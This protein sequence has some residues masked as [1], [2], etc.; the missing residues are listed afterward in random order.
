MTDGEKSE[1]PA[2]ETKPN[3]SKDKL[4]L[5]HWTQSFISQKVRLVINEKGLLCEE[6]DVSLPIAEHNEPWFMRL[7]LGEEVPVFIHGDT[8]VSDYNQIIQY[9]EANFGGETVAQLIPD[10]GSPVHECVQQYRELLDG[11]PMDAYTHGCIL[12]PELTTDSMIPKYA[13]AEIRRHLANAASEL[14]KLDHEEPTLTEPYLS[15]QK[16]LMAKILDHDNVTYLKKILGELAMVLDQ[17]EAELEKRKIEYEG[18][19]LHNDCIEKAKL[20]IKLFSGPWEGTSLWEK[21]KKREKKKREEKKKRKK[22]K[23][24]GLVSASDIL[25]ELAQLNFPDTDV[26]R[27]CL[28]SLVFKCG[29]ARLLFSYLTALLC[30]TGLESLMKKPTRTP[31]CRSPTQRQEKR[32]EMRPVCAQLLFAAI[33]CS[34][35]YTGAAA[36]RS[37]SKSNQT[38]H[39]HLTRPGF[40]SD[41]DSD[42]SNL[43][44]TSISVPRIRRRRAIS[45]REINSLLDYHNLVRSQVFPQAANMEIM[46]RPASAEPGQE[47]KG[48]LLCHILW[49]GLLTL[50]QI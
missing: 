32:V 3:F 26:K 22:K 50:N 4:V 14:L 29:S 2:I 17:V 18:P 36:V 16:K 47:N 41:P 1:E 46:V 6:R 39:L 21:K 27:S 49:L 42:W 40:E 20:P 23:T 7:N 44:L 48:L 37:L 35:P 43:N 34:M 38:N 30:S 33:L 31:C 25:R 24:G 10:A 19:S 9:L 28:Q 11:L 12:H 13:T 5:Y 15:K 8:I 45:S